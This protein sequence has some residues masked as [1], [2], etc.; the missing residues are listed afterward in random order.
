LFQGFLRVVLLFWFWPRPHDVDGGGIKIGFDVGGVVLLD[1]LH[2]GAAIFS[3]LV[4]ISAFHQA[5]ADICVSE[6]VSGSRAAFA[7]ESE[8][9]LV[10]DG[11][12]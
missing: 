12:E 8:I 2:A 9:F 1:H 6:A 3:D 4:D 10:E 7:I 5:Q 11:F